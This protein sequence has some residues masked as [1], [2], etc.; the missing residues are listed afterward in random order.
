MF[1]LFIMMASENYSNLGA[2]P[3]RV[4][5]YVGRQVGVVRVLNS[6]ALHSNPEFVFLSRLKRCRLPAAH[7]VQGWQW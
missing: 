2:L 1:F 4:G 6:H 7:T 3:R 5:R